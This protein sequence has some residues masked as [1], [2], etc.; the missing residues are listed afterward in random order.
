MATR[1]A[2][3][4]LSN[5]PNDPYLITGLAPGTYYVGVS[6]AGNLPYGSN[7]YDPNLG[8]PGSAAINQP[9]GPF[10]FEL[11]LAAQPHDQS[12]SL[13]DITVDRADL[14]DP[15]PTGLTLTFSG[16]IDLSNLFVPDSQVTSL[17]VVDSTGRVWPATAEEYQVTDARLTLIFDQPLP[18]G[19]Y[20]LIIPS[21]GGLNDLAGL[22]VAAPG[23]PPACWRPGLSRPPPCQELTTTWA[24]SGPG[25]LV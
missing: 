2:G 23:E 20:S 13:V 3:T 12:T 10:A 8:I 19:R 16:P 11:S 25:P 18:A 7:G 4:G 1:D 22:A 17:R 15:S 9:G 14:A 24:F 6:G 5:D 21:Q